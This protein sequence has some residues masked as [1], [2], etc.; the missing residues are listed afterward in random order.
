MLLLSAPALAEDPPRAVPAAAKWGW[1]G[2]YLGGHV[3]AFGGFADFSDPEGPSLYGDAA[4]TPGFIG[5][6]QAG[7]NWRFAP[8]WLLGFEASGSVLSSQGAN[9]CLQ[10]SPTIVGSNCRALPRGIATFTGRFGHIPGPQGRTLIY[11]KGGVA[12]LHSDVSINPN[13][14]NQESLPSPTSQSIGTWGWTAGAGVEYALTPSWSLNFEY[15]YLRFSGVGLATPE[16]FVF[17]AAGASAPVPAGSGVSIMT[18]DLHLAR[19]GLNYRWGV[20]AKGGAADDPPAEPISPP[21]DPG[22]EFDVGARYWYSTGQYQGANGGSNVLISRLTYNNITGHSGEIFARLDSPFDV[23]VKGLFGG[24]L[25]TNGMMIDEDW[26]PMMM[27][28]YSNSQHGIT[29]SFNYFT[30]DIG[31]DLMRGP[32]HK[33]GLFFGYN[34]YQFGMDTWGFS[35]QV[36]GVPE[37]FAQTDMLNQK[38]ISEYD[39]WHSLRAGV[40]AEAE[41][42]KRFKLSGDFAYLPYVFVDALDAHYTRSIFFPVEGIGNGVQAEVILSYRATESLS[43]GIGGRYW[44]M[45]TTGAGQTNRSNIF[46]IDTERYGMFV[47]ASY[48]FNKPR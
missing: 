29:G 34:R 32:D 10:A 20:A 3:G 27:L 22:W 47:Q 9:T 6:L 41:L 45:W 43:I 25:F 42:W 44:A 23:F 33:L 17:N 40:S 16:T 5:G 15:D 7:Y 19:L 2:F 38:G 30:F 26:D 37:S 14:S 4:F 18:Q 36:Y 28:P 48:K 46:T 24:G 1:T 35:Q 11:G 21:W 39:T 31:Y 12:W 8:Q 13:N